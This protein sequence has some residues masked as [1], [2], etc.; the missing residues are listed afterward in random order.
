[1]NKYYLAFLVGFLF[2]PSFVHACQASIV[3]NMELVAYAFPDYSVESQFQYKDGYSQN[4]ILYVKSINIV[5]SADKD[6]ENSTARIIITVIT[7]TG[8]QEV[9]STGFEYIPLKNGT[10]SIMGWKNSPYWYKDV[11]SSGIQLKTGGEYYLVPTIEPNYNTTSW[12]NA[13]GIGLGMYGADLI[14]YPINVYDRVGKF[15][16]S[17]QE[18]FWDL[19]VLVIVLALSLLASIRLG[20]KYKPDLS[21]ALWLLRTIIFS[22]CLSII[23]IILFM[24]VINKTEMETDVFSFLGL[25][26]N[27]FVV[28][29]GS[30]LGL[31]I[32]ESTWRKDTEIIP[33][34][35]ARDIS[36]QNREQN[37]ANDRKS[38]SPK[39]KVDK[40]R[41]LK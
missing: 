10:Y 38:A 39:K 31:R 25:A 1:M 36:K 11:I 22:S 3:G 29:F 18:L 6:C 37:E 30:F 32:V 35:K 9:L 20:L 13:V 24:G 34:I 27:I 23:V 19:V 14:E 7:P 28:I 41:P 15:K 21:A 12:G 8:N 16:I 26:G 2:L 40:K 33:A 5:V 4:D 17:T